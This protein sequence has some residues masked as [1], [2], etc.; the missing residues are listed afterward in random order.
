[1]IKKINLV[2]IT[3]KNYLP[4]FCVALSSLLKHN[5]SL[6][7]KVFLIHDL[8]ENKKILRVLDG[9]KKKYSVDIF[10]ITMKKSSEFDGFKI[11]HYVT[12]ATYY[13][14]ALADILPVEVKDVLY[15][16]SDL[17]VTGDLSQI[18]NLIFDDQCIAYAVN[19]INKSKEFLI[20]HGNK[21][22]VAFNN[23]YYNAGVMYLNLELMRSLESTANLF[24]IATKH[25]ENLRWWDQD[26]I[27]IYFLNMWAELDFTYNAC[28]LT[29]KLEY[30]PKIIHYSGNRK[31]WLGEILFQ[32]P[33]KD[34]YWAYL[35]E[36]PLR[37]SIYLPYFNAYSFR[38]IKSYI[39]RRVKD[40][41]KKY[42]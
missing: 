23:K 17:I 42:I 14:L 36:A 2:F 9:F 32:H 40:L 7:D 20:E 35:K 31:P 1:M 19:H 13:R 3:D 28:D 25:N 38:K 30:L 34:L 18:A 21:F 33:Y 24:A 15:L 29:E 5:S 16:D 8:I 39:P 6:I 27:N 37:W 12:K 10:P 4:Q 22:G 41:V 11:T 26:V